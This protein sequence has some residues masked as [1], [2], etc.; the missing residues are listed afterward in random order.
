MLAEVCLVDIYCIQK[1]VVSNL[2]VNNVMFRISI[3]IIIETSAELFEHD[4]GSVI[5]AHIDIWL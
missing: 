1:I 2:A 4:N 5:E 3:V